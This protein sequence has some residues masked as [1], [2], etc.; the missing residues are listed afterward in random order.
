[1]QIEVCRFRAQFP[2]IHSIKSPDKLATKKEK[3][4]QSKS[5]RQSEEYKG[6]HSNHL[7]CL[8][9]FQLN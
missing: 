4:N 9:Q 3:K 2:K 1:M 6:K 5:G 8:D 7:M